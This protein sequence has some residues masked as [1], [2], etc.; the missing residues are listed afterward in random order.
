MLEKEIL[1]FRLN[2]NSRGICQFGCNP[3][4]KVSQTG[5]LSSFEDVCF[6]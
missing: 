1:H 5:R 2:Q 3:N 4:F 6:S